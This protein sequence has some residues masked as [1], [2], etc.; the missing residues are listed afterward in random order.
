MKESK[1]LEPQSL[2]SDCEICQTLQDQLQG[3]PR[4][5]RYKWNHVTPTN[6]CKLVVAT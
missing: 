5:N 6:D 3:G 2:F 1:R 4:A